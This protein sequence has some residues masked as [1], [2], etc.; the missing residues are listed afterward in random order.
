MIRDRL[1]LAAFSGFIAAILAN[2]TL[3]VINQNIPGPTLNMPQLTV[4]IFLTV[5]EYTIIHEILGIIWSTIVGSTY[6]LIYLIALDLTGWHNLW[7]KAILVISA[8]WLL[9]AGFVMRLMDLA[10]G[11]RDAPLSMLAFFVAHL[12]FATYLYLL[13]RRYGKPGKTE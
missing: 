7:L 5:T 9:G 12:F 10:V 13:V 6:A 8:A 2:I 3:Y 11:T 4:E 1:L